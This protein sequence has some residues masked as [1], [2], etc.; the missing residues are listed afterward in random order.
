MEGPKSE[1]KYS[2]IVGDKCASQSQLVNRVPNG[3][4]KHAIGIRSN[5]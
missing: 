2:T 4:D 3:A 5:A 1:I